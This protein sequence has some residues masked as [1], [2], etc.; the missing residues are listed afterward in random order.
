M[1]IFATSQNRKTTIFAASQNRKMTIFATSR[2]LRLYLS[3]KVDTH[4]PFPEV[5]ESA[6]FPSFSFLEADSFDEIEGASAYMRLPIRTKVSFMTLELVG[7]RFSHEPQQFK[8]SDSCL[9]FCALSLFETIHIYHSESM[10]F[11][12]IIRVPECFIFSGFGYFF[13]KTAKDKH[14]FHFR[15]EAKAVFSNKKGLT[16]SHQTIA[17]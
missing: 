1:T 10:N 4:F 9:I 14:V 11:D 12:G 2:N 3:R 17:F 15:E 13:G 7:K 16:H 8:K 6:S 5:D